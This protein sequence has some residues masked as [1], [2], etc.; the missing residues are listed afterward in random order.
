MG[1]YGNL[2]NVART[3][4]SFDK[5]YSTHFEM[6]LKEASDQV[7]VGRYVLLDYDH[8]DDVNDDIYKLT[9]LV[10]YLIKTDLTFN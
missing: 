2:A 4:F 8:E 7:F 9:Q 1:F 5:T 6:V 10:Q 3:T